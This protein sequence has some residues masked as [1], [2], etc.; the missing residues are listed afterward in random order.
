MT[1]TAKIVVCDGDQTGQ[2]LLIEALRVL[3]EDVIG[4]PVELIHYDLSLANREKTNNGVVR[5]A[6]AAMS[7]IGLGLKAATITPEAIGSVGSPNRILREGI[8]GKVIVRVGRP[9]PGVAPVLSLSQP[10]VAIRMAVG[11]AYRAKEGREGD[12]G[13]SEEGAWRTAY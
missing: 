13:S 12:A 7:E 8:D 10:L 3:E 1:T 2:E 6:A 5:E 9:I 11:D 4:F